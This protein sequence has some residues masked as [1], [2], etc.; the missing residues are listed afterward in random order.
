[1]TKMSFCGID[2]VE[3]SLIVKITIPGGAGN[4]YLNSEGIFRSLIV[5]TIF[6]H[7]ETFKI[8]FPNFR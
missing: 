2:Y 5:F 7:I 4:L 8:I 1:M 6:F 3:L